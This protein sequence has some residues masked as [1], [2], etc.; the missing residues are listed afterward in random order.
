MAFVE[1]DIHQNFKE[2]ILWTT[3]SINRNL[4]HIYNQTCAKRPVDQITNCSIVYSSKTMGLGHRKTSER[5]QLK[6]NPEVWNDE[7]RG[8]SQ[9]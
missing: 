3:S 9:L 1:G 4:F 2:Y 5:R 7:G 8:G 6:L